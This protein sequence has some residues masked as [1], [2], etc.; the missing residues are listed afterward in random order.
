MGVCFGHHTN[1][2]LFKCTLQKVTRGWVKLAFHQGWHEVQDHNVHALH[3][4]ASSRFKTKQPATNDNSGAFICGHFDHALHIIK[5]TIGEHPIK[6][7]PRQWDNERVR[8]CCDHEFVV[9]SRN[10]SF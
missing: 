10:A 4:Q 7:M 9:R 5:I 2:K 6:I 8:T 1:A 3:L